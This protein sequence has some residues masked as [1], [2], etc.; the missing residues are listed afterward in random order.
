MAAAAEYHFRIACV[1]AAYIFIINQKL[2]SNEWG[3]GGIVIERKYD[4]ATEET[5]I[6]DNALLADRT[7]N[8]VLV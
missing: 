5:E 7:G 4:P 3:G 6:K 2:N 1:P 8:D